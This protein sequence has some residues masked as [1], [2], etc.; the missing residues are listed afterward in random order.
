MFVS[1]PIPSTFAQAKAFLAIAAAVGQSEL[2]IGKKNKLVQNPDGSIGLVYYE[3]QIVTF[4]P[5]ESLK[6]F[7]GKE[8][9]GG[10]VSTS[11]AKRLGD[12]LSTRGKRLSQIE[13]FWVVRPLDPSQGFFGIEALVD[14]M[15]IP[16]PQA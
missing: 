11:T 14:G 12:V 6:I 10:K 13:G 8:A 4:Q 15:T 2:M 1:L 16:A 9:T 7:T 5:D 3:T